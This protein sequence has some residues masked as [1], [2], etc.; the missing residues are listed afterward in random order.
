MTQSPPPTP[1]GGP[2]VTPVRVTTWVV[3]AAIGVF[4]L[5]SGITGIIAKG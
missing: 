2:R 4:L 1:G 5:V 3:V